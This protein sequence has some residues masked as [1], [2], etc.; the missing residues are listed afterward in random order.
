MVVDFWKERHYVYWSDDHIAY[1]GVPLMMLGT[2]KSTDCHHGKDRNIKLK[3]LNKK[4]KKSGWV[5]AS[6]FFLIH[7]RE[8]FYKE[9][10]KTERKSVV[11]EAV[12]Y[13]GS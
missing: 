9:E 1:T 12:S 7:C 3:E 2:I 4:K 5:R 8:K 13:L 11:G 10:S 6:S